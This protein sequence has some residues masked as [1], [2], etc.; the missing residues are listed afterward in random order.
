[1]KTRSFPT[2]LLRLLLDPRVSRQKK[3]A[4]PLIIAAYWVL[5]D[6]LPFLPMDDL[7][8]TALM[9][10]WFTRS[11]EKDVPQSEAKSRFDKKVDDKYVDVQAEV[12]DED[13]ES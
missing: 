3:L 13:E 6:L 11:A 7:L 1:M 4:F 9:T 5:P 12:V 2:H 10:Y 8:F